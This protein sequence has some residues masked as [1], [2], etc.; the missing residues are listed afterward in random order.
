MTEQPD[1]APAPKRTVASALTEQGAS[2]V[3]FTYD[4]NGWPRGEHGK[5]LC[6]V[7][8]K[9]AS[10]GVTADRNAD[11]PT[12]VIQCAPCGCAV[13]RQFAVPLARALLEAFLAAD[14][15]NTPQ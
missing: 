15:T 10:E 3:D 9:H 14:T 2:R 8:G 6:P 7:C 5:L 12:T 4:W 1:A 13:P 11:Q